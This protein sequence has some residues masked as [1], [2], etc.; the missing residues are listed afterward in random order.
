MPDITYN[1]FPISG[2][3]VDFDTLQSDV[4]NLNANAVL[5]SRTINGYDLSEN[6]TIYAQ[7]VPSRNILSST[8]VTTTS[9]NVTFTVN[10]DGSVTVSTS[11]TAS[12]WTSFILGTATLVSGVTY[13]LTGC[14]SGGSQ[15]TFYQDIQGYALYDTGS[16]RTLSGYSG[17]YTA[18]IVV[19]SGASCNG[20]FYPMI[21]PSTAPAGYVPYAKT[22]VELSQLFTTASISCSLSEMSINASGFLEKDAPYDASKWQIVGFTVRS[23]GINDMSY[24]TVYPIA[25]IG[26]GTKVYIGYYNRRTEAKTRQFY[27]DL[28]L[29]RK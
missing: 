18:R 29:M 15:S 26:T 14:P 19:Q 9:N 13:E 11:G 2:K 20:T 22:N 1:Q 16:G 8:G 6:R 27:L 4:A 28:L 12:A 21:R 25:T 5:E 10:S 7:D 17:T 24:V 23:D 3:I